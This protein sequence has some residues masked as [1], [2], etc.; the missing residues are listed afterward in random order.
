MPQ[1]VYLYLKLNVG[2]LEHPDRVFCLLLLE[3]SKVSNWQSGMGVGEELARPDGFA[4][5]MGSGLF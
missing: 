3:I 4:V 1:Q 2:W 5:K